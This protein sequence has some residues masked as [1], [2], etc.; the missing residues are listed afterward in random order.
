MSK[1][2]LFA[3]TN[4]QTYA[5]LDNI[6]E[7]TPLP[8]CLLTEF[9]SEQTI[10]LEIEKTAY[11]MLRLDYESINDS[12]INNTFNVKIINC[13][14]HYILLNKQI[15]KFKAHI[16]PIE[17]YINNIYNLD[18][19]KDSEYDIIN[20]SNCILIINNPLTGHVWIINI[21][22]INNVITSKVCLYLFMFFY[23]FLYFFIFFYVF[24]CF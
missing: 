14:I 24:L 3:T 12:F 16:L 5:F 21:S 8:P 9:A 17:Y 7:G 23:I 18:T 11:E 19:D 4:E 2:Y 13:F 10:E 1:L 15:N 20:S 6:F 22:G